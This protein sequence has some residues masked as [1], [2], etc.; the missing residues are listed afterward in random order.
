MFNNLSKEI[1]W[2]S[3]IPVIVIA[4]IILLLII[5]G[6]KKDDNYFQYNYGIKVL[7]AI[8]VSL[9]LSIMAGYTIWFLGRISSVSKNIIYI[10]LLFGVDIFLF[11][12]LII[13]V[14]KLYKSINQKKELSN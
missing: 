3:V 1:I 11:I 14:V 9:V 6:K 2:Y 10:I 8:L 13:I 5:V 12:L 4:L 7:L